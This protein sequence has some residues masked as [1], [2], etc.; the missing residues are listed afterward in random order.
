[1]H[2]RR[3]DGAIEAETSRLRLRLDLDTLGLDVRS[4]QG[5]TRLIGARAAVDSGE[6]LLYGERT[7]VDGYGDVRS[8]AGLATRID[9]RARGARSLELRLELDVAEEWPGLSLQ[10][11]VTNRGDHA[12][13]IR[14][15]LPLRVDVEEGG[16]FAFPFP[17]EELRFFRMG[18]QSWTPAGYFRVTEQQSRPRLGFLR[19]LHQGPV[20]PAPQRGLHVSDFVTTLRSPGTPALT[21]G[22]TSHHRYL[23][24]V[25]LR[26]RGAEVRGLET[27]V[28]ME[29][30]WLA[31]GDCVQGERLWL[32]IDAA[33]SD[34][35]AEWAERT[36]RE[37]DAPVPARVGT[38]W[39]SWYQFFTRVTAA[40]IERNVKALGPLLT[41]I[42]TVQIDDGYQ[43][44][45][46]DW[47]E[48]DSGFPEGIAPLAATIRSAGFR[49]GIW[50]APFLVS[51]ASR[52]AREHP[53]WLL[54][55]AKGRPVVADI[56]P[57]WKGMVCYAV[58]PTHEEV[59]SW[60]AEVVS[61]LRGAGF[62]Y[63]K[64]DFL[65][66]GTLAGRRADPTQTLAAAYREAIA[67]MRRAA[68]PN[69]FLLGCGAP[70][71]PSVGLFEAMRIGP[72]VAPR[73]R[74]RA[75][76]AVVGLSAAPS[77]R[78]AVRNV[79]ARAALHQRLWIN[80]P[81]CVL[82]RDRSTRL[83]ED[84]VRT[85]A[86]AALTS[87]GL[88]LIS[89]DL[90]NLSASR[91]ELFE[92]LIPP[93]GRTPDT[94]PASGAIPEVLT[95]SFPDGS[96]LVLVTNLG[97]KPR[98]PEIRLS[99]LGLSAPI[100]VYD[101]WQDRLETL[102]EGELRIGP[103]APHAC[104]LLRLAPIDGR[105]RV[106]GSTLHLSGGAVEAEGIRVEGPDGVSLR[107]RVPSPRRGRVL[108]DPGSGRPVATHVEFSGDLELS[109]SGGQTQPAGAST[110][111]QQGE[112]E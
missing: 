19:R 80:D 25:L 53:D 75:E 78:N 107:L 33:G 111:K 28:A 12:I 9:L 94:G 30:R 51:R 81:D 8:R 6:R 106:V 91:R 3:D 2:V 13:P 100:H 24:H 35:L 50:L 5:A 42:E 98:K 92:R 41:P 32:G 101:V 15:L 55:S 108:V 103:L 17:A 22:F 104:A 77:A 96:L 95:Q 61:T 49:A 70:I 1:V 79:L 109:V 112:T 72:D 93:L 48:W 64:L 44:A 31:P 14:R 59:R 40:D 16:E 68:E 88:L 71:G 26:S 23:T 37:M 57:N 102:H 76:D 58:D 18:Y 11:S 89:D 74:S 60:L 110:T 54:R 52:V 82:L 21:L 86:A 87:G 99:T 73:W 34:G 36:G 43:A 20:T 47:L 67:E 38:G 7:L 29:D 66:A 90:A 45:V 65:Y 39:C 69:P 62:D 105:P 83:S 46:G 85:V 4:A 97:E 10:L 63:L 56:N 27:A 84:E